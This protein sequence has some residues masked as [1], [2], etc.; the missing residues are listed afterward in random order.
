MNPKEIVRKYLE[1]N[2]F[3]GLF[4]D[5][6]CACTKDDLWWGCCDSPMKDCEPGY[7]SPCDCSEDHAFHI[8]PERTTT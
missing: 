5:G 4:R 8:G 1:E 6:K 2:G 7:K 3:D